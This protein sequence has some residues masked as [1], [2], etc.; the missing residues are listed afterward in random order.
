MV[1]PDDLRFIDD[2][3]KPGT[4]QRLLADVA[5]GTDSALRSHGAGRVCEGGASRRDC[6][7]FC[8]LGMLCAGGLRNARYSDVGTSSCL[9]QSRGLETLDMAFIFGVRTETTT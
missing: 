3:M 4:K 5:G 1:G 9:I 2:S 6:A 8:A 7:W